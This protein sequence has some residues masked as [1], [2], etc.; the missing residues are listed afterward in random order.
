MDFQKKQCLVTNHLDVDVILNLTHGG[1]GE[2]GLLASLFEFYDLPYIGPRREACAVSSNKFLTKG[3]AHSVN[4]KTIDY[5]YY[6]QNDKVEVD[7]FP[8]IVKPVR[9]EFYGCFYCEISR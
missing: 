4:V 6:T 3:Y 1:D 9:L 2:D 5:N 8:V 7:S